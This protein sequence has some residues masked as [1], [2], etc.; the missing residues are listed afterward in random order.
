MAYIRPNCMQIFTNGQELRMRTALANSTLL[1]N[2][3]V[4]NSL[5][6]NSLTVGSGV[7]RLYDVVGDLTAQTNVVVQSNGT[8]TLR[9]GNSI[10]LKNLFHAQALSS[11]QAYIEPSC[12]TIDEFNSA[13]RAYP[14]SEEVDTV[15]TNT[16][17]DNNSGFNISVYP[18]PAG[19]QLSID[20]LSIRSGVVEIKIFSVTG[21]LVKAAKYSI[22]AKGIYRVQ[23]DI[24][25]LTSGTYI[26][27][28]STGFEGAVKKFVKF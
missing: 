7:S 24:S 26:M 19:K 25:T 3:I 5:V 21:T 11:F 22:S 13:R 16:E 18:N 10:V 28:A 17:T 9:A 1:Q 2:V 6:I 15:K 14:Y 20:I 23:M 8:L 27:Q 4:P 12:S